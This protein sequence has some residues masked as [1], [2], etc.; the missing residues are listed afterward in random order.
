[1]GTACP[2]LHVTTEGYADRRL[3]DRSVPKLGTVTEEE[4]CPR[5]D[6]ESPTN[7]PSDDPCPSTPAESPTPSHCGHPVLAAAEDLA[8][9]F[10]EPLGPLCSPPST[11]PLFPSPCT[12]LDAPV[13]GT[14]FIPTPSAALHLVV[15][16]AL[17]LLQRG[18]RAHNP[19][20]WDVFGTEPGARA[21]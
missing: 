19:Y 6:C 2:H 20:A 18:H 9:D 3:W 14:N 4:F 11:P 1:M 5:C 10:D 15:P 12:Q 17:E 8:E 7:S 13:V 21:P 16:I